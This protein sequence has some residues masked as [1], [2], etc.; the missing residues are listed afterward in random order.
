MNDLHLQVKKAR[1][2]LILQQFMSVVFWC[3]LIGL[4]VAAIG[5]AIPK[6]WPVG[7]ASH[8]WLWSWVGGSLGVSLLAALLW[9]FVKRNSALDAAMELD[10]RCGLRE[11]V[12]STLSLSTEEQSTAA[13]RALIQ[14]AVRRVAQVDVGEHF[15]VR[16]NR[17]AWL[18]IVMA[19]VVFGL[20]FLTDAQPDNAQTLNAAVVSAAKPIKKSTD[21]LKKKLAERKKLALEE[22]LKDAGDLFDKL[23]K[24]VEGMNKKDNVSKKDA[25]VKLNDLAKDIK[26]RK[27]ELGDPS[28]LRKQLNQLKDIKQG[29]AEKLAKALKDG[30]YQAAM[31]EIKNL[32]EAMKNGDMTE[33]Q[34]EKLAA[35]MDQLKQK[36]QEMAEAQQQAKQDLQ[37]QLQQKMAQGDR[38][39][40]EEIQK[41]LD[42]M[43]QQDQ[44]MQQMKDL[45]QKL[46]QCSQA[47]KNG[48]G[49]QASQQL[50]EISD[51]LESLQQE[52]DELEMLEDALGQIDQSKDQMNCQ[53]CN[54]EGCS[55][56]QGMGGMAGM[57]GMG[58]M[59][60]MGM[61]EG[62]GQGDRPEE[63]TGTGFYDSQV[64]TKPGRGRAVITG[65]AKGENRAGQALEEIKSEIATAQTSDDDPLTGQRLPKR[66]RELAKEYF[67]AFREGK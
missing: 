9:T 10:H 63:E 39:A 5:V 65:I 25:M 56:C 61:G 41:K 32:Q 24:S 51:Q 12:S 43:A 19:C 62:Q 28:E 16:P 2:R 22:G 46:G 36:L 54:G 6:I 52:M 66:Q 42:Q 21:D 20:T 17:F 34:Q 44:Q 55:M 4:V 35:Q 47:M 27:A 53:N 18:P 29:P 57:G 26:D 60:G 45:A 49:Q 59:P 8:V 64:R 67:D 11:R 31:D 58:Q 48:D 13:G 30:D 40:A 37:K 33:A 15:H 23:E 50:A 38:Q 7:V 1:R 14:D 3:L